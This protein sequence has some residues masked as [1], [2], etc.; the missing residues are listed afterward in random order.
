MYGQV[1]SVSVLAEAASLCEERGA[2]VVRVAS[3]RWSH[4]SGEREARAPQEVSSKE[5]HW[6]G[7]Y[8]R[9]ARGFV[10]GTGWRLLV[11]FVEVGHIDGAVPPARRV[12]ARRDHVTCG[13]VCYVF[14][15]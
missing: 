10:R 13:R 7:G 5:E 12:F 9:G 4:K 2:R 6:E 11:R 1:I 3:R 15:N 8:P 14:L